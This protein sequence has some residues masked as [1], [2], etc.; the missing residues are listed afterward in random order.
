MSPRI[1]R[2]L[3]G[4]SA[5][6]GLL[7][8]SFI[9]CGQKIVQAATLRDCSFQR[10]LCTAATV[11]YA[12]R[13]DLSSAYIPFNRLAELIYDRRNYAINS[14]AARL[15]DNVWAL[16][17]GSNRLSYVT[18]HILSGSTNRI[19]SCRSFAYWVAC[20]SR[21]R[22][23]NFINGRSQYW[24]SLNKLP[25]CDTM[26]R[27]RFAIVSGTTKRLF[28]AGDLTRSP[29]ERRNKAL[30]PSNVSKP[31]GIRFLAGGARLED[32][33]DRAT[34][35]SVRKAADRFQKLRRTNASDA[36]GRLSSHACYRCA[37]RVRIQPE[38]A[39]SNS[40]CSRCADRA[41][42]QLARGLTSNT[43]RGGRHAGMARGKQRSPTGSSGREGFGRVLRAK[44]KVD[45]R[46]RQA[47]DSRNL[48]T[49]AGG[50]STDA[51]GGPEAEV[52]T[53]A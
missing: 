51:G 14:C 50:H 49:L 7:L 27:K 26:L 29:T 45:W 30:L 18:R 21:Q 28:C 10:H 32:V 22:G 42:E 47:G 17:G 38:I 46:A 9:H 39:L 4:A 35:R 13:Y 8:A 12:S 1:G 34:R 6:R 5:N 11:G 20:P 15:W 33:E 40:S 31:H 44:R 23:R 2:S 43:A 41:P 37:G 36:S 24:P 25:A 53:L 48:A 52:L 16:C 3:N 19:A